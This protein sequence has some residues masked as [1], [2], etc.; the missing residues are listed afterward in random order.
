MFPK[1]K[2]IENLHGGL[3]Q[4]KVVVREL[5][6]QKKRLSDG[7]MKDKMEAVVGT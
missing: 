6:S 5:Q 2:V 3:E 7:G 4:T 1:A